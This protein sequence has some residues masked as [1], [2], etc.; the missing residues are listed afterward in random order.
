MISP[1]MWLTVMRSEEIEQTLH[2]MSE[3][4][5]SIDRRSSSPLVT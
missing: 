2:D 4:L 3:R 1:C 5:D